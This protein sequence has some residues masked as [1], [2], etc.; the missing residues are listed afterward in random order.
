MRAMAADQL[1]LGSATTEGGIGGNL[2]NSICAIEVDGETCRLQKDAAVISYGQYA[3]AILITSRAH[4]DAAS[5]DQ[6][7]TVFLK[8]QYT[9]ELTQGWDTLGMR[10]TCSEGYIFKGEAPAEQIFPSRLPRLQPN[11]CWP[12]RICCGVV[13]GTA[14]RWMPLFALGFCSCRSP[15]DARSDASRSASFWRDATNLLQLVRSE[16][17]VGLAPL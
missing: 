12:V 2:R 16:I 4:A 1:L 8:D 6:V 7:M 9:L 5:S 3:D 13:S 17:T 10:G 15:Q 11:P 14:S